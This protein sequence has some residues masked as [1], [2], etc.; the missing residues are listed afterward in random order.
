M[1]I[2][3]ILDLEIFAYHGVFEEEAALGQKFLVSANLYVDTREAGIEDDLSKSIDYGSVCHF[4]KSVMEETRCKL[5]ETVA[6]NIANQ[7]L[8]SYDLL[9]QVDIE[10]KKPWAPILLPI[11]TVSVMIT[12]SWHTAYLGIGSN[13]GDKEGY[14]DFAIDQLNEDK[15]T[16]VVNVSEYI[17]TEPYG[18]VEQE[19]FVNGCLQ[20]HTLRM[21]LELLKLAND[22]ESLAKRERVIKWG[23]RTLDIDIL[24]YDHE[25]VYEDN[26][27]IPHIDLHKRNFV[28]EPLNMIAPYYRHPIFHKTVCELLEDLNN[29]K[30]I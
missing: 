5:I 2:I 30:I 13:I 19:D 25:V 18:D 26:L 11:K 12:R 20:V 1:D 10:V 23:P 3:K 4:I 8:L 24:F 21:P 9:K 14:L 27:I 22:I 28:L 17:V 29:N 16:K 7:L 15:Y 6:E